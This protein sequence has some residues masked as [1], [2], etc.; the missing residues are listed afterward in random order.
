MLDN[1]TRVPGGYEFVGDDKKIVHV[2]TPI[3]H[4]RMNM[5]RLDPILLQ[6]FI[7]NVVIKRGVRDPRA[8]EHPDHQYL[9]ITEEDLDSIETRGS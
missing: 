4:A 7:A 5:L 2:H 8:A 9:E 6:H 1:F 3:R